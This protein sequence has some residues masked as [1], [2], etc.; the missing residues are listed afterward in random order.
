M[1]TDFNL[2]DAFKIFDVKQLGYITLSD[3]KI[4]LADLGLLATYDE[5]ELFLKRYDKDR[6]GKLRFS[7][8]C[9]AFIPHDYYLSLN[10]NRR[11]TNEFRSTYLPR[12]YCFDTIT[13]MEFKNLW[14]THFKVETSA[15]YLRKRL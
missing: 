14:R 3:I 12:D 1:R 7:E 9:D 11:N 4:T 15:E 2:F 5:V 10:L 13:R 6:D 8:F